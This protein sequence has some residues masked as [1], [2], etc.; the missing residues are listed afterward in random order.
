MSNSGATSAFSV[1]SSSVGSP[2]VV[3]FTPSVARITMNDTSN[4]WVKE[5][6]GQLESLIQLREGWDGYHARPVSFSTAVFAHNMLG[7]LFLQGLPPPDLVPG[8][9]G[10][11][12]AEWHIGDTDIELHVRAPNSVIA[13]RA[14]P[15]TGEDGEEIELKNDFTVVGE[16]IKQLVEAGDANTSAAA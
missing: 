9:A 16:W 14:T 8:Y 1:G 12:Q 7:R 15:E 6:E 3:N 10:D 11:V 13:W 5:L 2:K 4:A